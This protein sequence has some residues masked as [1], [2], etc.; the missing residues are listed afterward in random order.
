ITVEAMQKDDLINFY[1]AM[2][3]T[4]LGP[5]VYNDVNGEYKGWDQ[6]I[7]KAE[8]FTNY[9]TLSLW[10]TYRTLHPFFNLVQPQRNS[11]MIQSMLAHQLQSVH[12]MLPVSSHYANENWCMSGYHAVTVIADAIV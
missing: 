3:H 6:N 12:N 8:G 11:D 4:F 1:T 7:H 5:T 10:D 9:T 2:Y